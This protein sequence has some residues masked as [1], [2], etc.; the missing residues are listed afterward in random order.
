MDKGWRTVRGGSL[1]NIDIGRGPDNLFIHMTGQ[2]N[3]AWQKVKENKELRVSIAF[4]IEMNMRHG[5]PPILEIPGTRNRAVAQLGR[6]DQHDGL[7][8][9][10][11]ALRHDHAS[12]W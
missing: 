10:P 9:H 1:G 5:I 2:S 6:R 11:D 7:L 12:A 4:P 3:K 8:L